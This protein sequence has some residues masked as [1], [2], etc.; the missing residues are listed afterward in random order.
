MSVIPKFTRIF[1]CGIKTN[2]KIKAVFLSPLS[3]STL[4]DKARSQKGFEKLPADM[5]VFFVIA[6]PTGPDAYEREMADQ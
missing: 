3:F 2:E 1:S 5:G 4:N 6:H